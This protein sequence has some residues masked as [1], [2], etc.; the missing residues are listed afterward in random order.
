MNEAAEAPSRCSDGLLFVVGARRSGTLWLHRILASH[1][2]VAAIPAETHLFSHGIAPLFERFQHGVRNSVLTGTVYVERETA[3]AKARELCD[4]VFEPHRAGARWLLE[5][6]PFHVHELELIREVYPDARMIQ[7]IRDGRDVARSLAVQGWGPGTVAE[8]A[9]EWRD[10]VNAGRD[11]EQPVDLYRE[12]RYESL[13]ADPART[14]ADLFAWLGLEAGE[15]L[16]ERAVAESRA[17]ANVGPSK[18]GG[19]GAGKWRDEWSQTEIAAFEE[20]AGELLAELGYPIATAERPG[21][22]AIGAIE[23]R[24]AGR[25]LGG[26][27][28]RRLRR[29]INGAGAVDPSHLHQ[30]LID[31]LISGLAS[32]SREQLAELLADDAAVELIAGERPQRARRG[33]A[34][35]AAGGR[36]RSRVREPPAQRR[37][38]DRDPLGDDDPALRERRRRGHDPARRHTPRRR[39]R[40]AGVAIYRLD[41]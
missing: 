35:T 29:R 15:D 27:I 17:L 39:G 21:A 31:E 33:C 11:A 6:T 30:T 16:I 9:R 32:R 22:G 13:L 14:A 26:A 34:G 23:G 10:A 41:P 19:V 5:R 18:Q 20:N 4:L 8:A 28:G 1:P 40:L 37:D 38:P 3:I 24:S 7:I 25:R 36:R 12:V 2:E